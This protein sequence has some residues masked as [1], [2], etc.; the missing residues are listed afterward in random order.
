VTHPY[1]EDPVDPVDR[2]E[3]IKLMRA[4]FGVFAVTWLIAGFLLGMMGATIYAEKHP[5][6]NQSYVTVKSV[7]YGVSPQT[8]K[9]EFPRKLDGQSCFIQLSGYEE[10]LRYPISACT[11]LQAEQKVSVFTKPD[12]IR[13]D[14]TEIPATFNG[15]RMLSIVAFSLSGLSAIAFVLAHKRVRRTWDD[16]IEKLLSDGNQ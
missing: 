6:E 10:P 2:L 16:A 14:P 9:K 13:I 7:G 3:T 4:A 5:N 12:S 1:G 8:A 15:T 11:A